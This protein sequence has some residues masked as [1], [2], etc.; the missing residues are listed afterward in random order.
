MDEVQPGIA[1]V[2]N[3]LI[4]STRDAAAMPAT[5][6]TVNSTSARAAIRSM[7][8]ISMR[9]PWRSRADALIFEL[10]L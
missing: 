7:K 8:G 9:R 1:N 2:V 4:E 5:K 3:S 6:T 10:P